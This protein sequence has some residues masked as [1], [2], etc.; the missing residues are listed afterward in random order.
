MSDEL[1]AIDRRHGLKATMEEATNRHALSEIVFQMTYPEKML[2]L[3]FLTNDGIKILAKVKG[4]SDEDI[5]T[6]S[7]IGLKPI[8]PD[9]RSTDKAAV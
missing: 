2:L 3:Q 7:A 4:L 6:F 5:K 9:R 8:R 1:K